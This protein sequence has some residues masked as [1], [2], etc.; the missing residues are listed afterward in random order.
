MDILASSLRT[1]DRSSSILFKGP[2]NSASGLSPT[3]GTC[4]SCFT[5]IHSKQFI[6][7]NISYFFIPLLVRLIRVRRHV[8]RSSRTTAR[9]QPRIVD[10]NGCKILYMGNADAHANSLSSC[11]CYHHL[12]ARIRHGGPHYSVSRVFTFLSTLRSFDFRNFS[13]A[14]ESDEQTS[15]PRHSFHGHRSDIRR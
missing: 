14:T 2:P 10:P 1:R 8:R 6:N 5:K 9:G 11:H 12:P 3:S 15:Q 7:N 4:E 13:K